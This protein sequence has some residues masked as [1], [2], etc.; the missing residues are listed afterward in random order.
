MEDRYDWVLALCFGALVSLGLVM[1]LSSSGPLAEMRHSGPLYYFKRQA[2][3]VMAGGVAMVL[4]A[5][6]PLRPIRHLTYPLLGLSLLLLVLVLIP[7]FGKK[8]GV[9]RRWLA[10]P[11]G[12]FQP[13][14][15][16]KFALVL[17]LSHLAA[18]KEEEVK[19]F[20]RG[21]LPPL[22]ITG[23]F[24]VLLLL[25][26]D[27]GGALF[28]TLLAFVL[29]FL[30]G[31]RLGHLVLLPLASS[32][33]VL[34]LLSRRGYALKRIEDFLSFLRDPSQV[35]YQLWQSFVALSRGGLLGTGLG[36]GKQKLFYLP[37]AHT[38]FIFANLGEELGFV[39]VAGVMVLFGLILLRGMRVALR[40]PDPFGRNLAAGIT[41][42]IVL[43]AVINMGVVLGLLPTKGLPLPFI[44]YGGSALMV[45]MAAAG[46]LLNLSRDVEV[47]SRTKGR[48][49]SAYS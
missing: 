2:L 24:T 19:D 10:T 22:L 18:K 32:P 11:L 16:G 30:F 4:T 35:S 44:S 9:A 25:E 26:P 41:V 43:Q 47:P 15:L 37:A 23:T 8:V 7:P 49:R 3:F 34:L 21:F 12:T 1:V 39:G 40:H 42:M 48:W 29:L 31:W 45:E 20:L 13:S 27:I 28:L 38:D 33:V 5:R 36:E 17:Y 46:V 14:E 6:V